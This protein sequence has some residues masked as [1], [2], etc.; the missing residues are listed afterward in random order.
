MGEGLGVREIT[1]LC[2]TNT[3]SLQLK[4]TFTLHGSVIATYRPCRM[5]S[6]YFAMPHT[7]SMGLLPANPLG[8]DDYSL[9]GEIISRRALYERLERECGLVI[10]L[11]NEQVVS[12]LLQS[13]KMTGITV[14]SM[15]PLLEERCGGKVVSLL[16]LQ[17][18]FESTLSRLS[19]DVRRK[20]RKSAKNG[21]VVRCGGAELMDSFYPVYRK[22]IHR[23]GSFGLTKR[24]MAGLLGDGGNRLFV[25]FKGD[26]A[27]GSALL[28]MEERFAENNAFATDIR[29]NRLY[30][31]YALHHAM[32]EYASGAGCVCYSFGRST[33]G[34]A[35]H[36][37]KQQWGTTDRVLWTCSDTPVKPGSQHR[38]VRKVVRL[39]PQW[40]SQSLDGIVAQGFY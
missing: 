4:T 36:R 10:D 17:D 5:G 40:I 27:V 6:K 30:T 8:Q 31:S 1:Y 9:I 29:F 11:G 3:N 37:Y 39:L 12:G 25:A 33:P 38:L 2:C 20:I 7:D 14:R 35:V 26:L 34:S 22:T 24:C 21:I 13:G 18:G 32:M 15:I 19:T 23:H 28:M 16:P